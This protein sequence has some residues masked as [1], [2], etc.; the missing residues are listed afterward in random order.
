[1]LTGASKTLS[2]GKN[3]SNWKEPLPL[4]MR[5]PSSTVQVVPS[6]VSTVLK[7]PGAATSMLM[8]GIGGGQDA[9]FSAPPCNAT[10]YRKKPETSLTKEMARISRKALKRLEWLIIVTSIVPQR[11]ILLFLLFYVIVVVL[12]IQ[13]HHLPDRSCQKTRLRS[14]Q[15]GGCTKRNAVLTES[16][17][18]RCTG[19]GCVRPARKSLAGIFPISDASACLP[20]E[21]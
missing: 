15:R 19:T 17:F 12:G 10:M 9:G 5:A 8:V 11:L 1:M 14:S 6:V 13:E 2:S 18:A 20:H 16:T 7:A 4:Q 21:Q 3:T